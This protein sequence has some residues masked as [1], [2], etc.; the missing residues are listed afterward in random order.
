MYL[1]VIG[2]S[3][4]SLLLNTVLLGTIVSAATG[5]VLTQYYGVDVLSSL[6]NEPYDCVA[7]WGIKVGRHCFS[8][9]TLPLKFAMRPNPWESDP[10][11]LPAYFKPAHNNYPAAAM[12]PELAFGML[13]HVVGAPR[14]GLLCYL[15]ALTVSCSVPAV[16]AAR[17]VGGPERLLILAVCGVAA[18][19][20]WMAIDRGNSVGFAVPIM[21]AF[22]VALCRRRWG[23]VVALVIL[24]SLVRPQ[25]VILA[26][27]LLA[28]RQWRMGLTA[29]AGSIVLNLAAYG[30]WPRY[31]PSTII[32]TVHNTLGYGSFS[33]SVSNGNVSFAK[34]L[35]AVLDGVKA[36]QTGGN[37][38]DGFLAGPRSVIGYVVLALIVICA[39]VLGRR[40]PPVMVG[41]VALAAASL[42]PAVSNRYYLV[43]AL[44]VAALVVRDPNGQ[45]G[46]GIFDRSLTVGGRRRAVGLCVCFASAVSIAQI[47]LPGPP[48]RVAITGSAVEI[49]TILNLAVTTVLFVPISWLVTCG[50]ILTSYARRSDSAQSSDLPCPQEE[51]SQGAEPASSAADDV[52][53]LSA[54]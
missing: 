11:F 23:H 53:A 50:V 42:S 14:L 46:I 29:V 44:A 1:E 10:P 54:K 12:V 26:I 52:P 32:Q 33:L 19:P 51:R 47:A 39:L 36:G 27:P 3:E 7:D 41:I 37:I 35:L 18:V 13:G 16:W 5:F 31:F 4:R 20:A 2:L 15:V 43:F 40:I 45:P 22:L 49:D 28:A 21:L 17:G 34:G 25:F 48:I 8:D 9:Y 6:L 38:P 30:L 24:A